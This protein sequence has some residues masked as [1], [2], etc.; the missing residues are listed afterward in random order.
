M[1][2]QPEERAASRTPFISSGLLGLTS[3]ARV[4]DVRSNSCSSSTRFAASS[5]LRI[6]M[7]RNQARLHRIN[8]NVDDDWNCRGRRFGSNCRRRATRDDHGHL[9][10]NEIGY[11]LGRSSYWPLNHWYSKITFWPSA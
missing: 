6:A 1:Q 5:D 4:V 8:A 2:L 7:P 9:S 3:V 11:Q 10:V